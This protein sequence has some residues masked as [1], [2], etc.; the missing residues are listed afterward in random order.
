MVMLAGTHID[1][2]KM[3]NHTVNNVSHSMVLSSYH[4]SATH[5]NLALRH[6]KKRQKQ[7]HMKHCLVRSCRINTH[8]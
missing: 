7:A 6:S 4:P 8:R 1:S 2:R 5:K 3:M